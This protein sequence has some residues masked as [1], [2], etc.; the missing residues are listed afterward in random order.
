MSETRVLEEQQRYYRARAPEYDQ[1]WLRRGRYDLGPEGNR[2]WFR[3][4][5]E[6]RDAFE[7]APLGGEVLE[8]AGGTGIWT[9][10]LAARASQLTVIDGAEE[11]L[12]INAERL[13][14]AGLRDKVRYRQADLFTW[15]PAR[16]YDT[17]FFGFWLSHVPASLLD[18]FLQNVAAALR[19]GGTLAIIDSRADD[20]SR[21]KQGTERV[22]EEHERREIDDGR[23]FRIVKRYEAPAE[24]E[25]R[26]AACGIRAQVKTTDLHLLYAIGQRADDEG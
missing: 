2:A 19:V 10:M 8:I 9:E 6:V 7:A 12:G 26:L 18:G 3:Q 21:R 5:A 17:V 11:M 23:I 22:G 1:W 25:R 4:V 24:L 13:T 14:R 20:E 16:R 15:R